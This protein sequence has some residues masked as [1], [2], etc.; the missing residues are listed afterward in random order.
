MIDGMNSG[1]SLVMAYYGT[2]RSSRPVEASLHTC[3]SRRCFNK[4][5]FRIQLSSSRVGNEVRVGPGRG[6]FHDARHEIGHD[7]ISKTFPLMVWVDR[8]V[9]NVEIPATI[10]NDS[11]HANDKICFVLDHGGIPRS[12]ECEL[13]LMSRLR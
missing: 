7:G 6:F 13:R 1:K 9:Y 11:A 8:H 4:T 5:P 2:S 12:L 3:T 10:C